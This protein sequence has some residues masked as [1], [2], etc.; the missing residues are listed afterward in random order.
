LRNK[1]LFFTVEPQW[2]GTGRPV[3]YGVVQAF[4]FFEEH[5]HVILGGRALVILV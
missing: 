2:I 5:S 4:K 3:F 1:P